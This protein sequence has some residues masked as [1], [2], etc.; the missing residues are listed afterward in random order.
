MIPFIL[1]LLIAG[2]SFIVKDDVT[3]PSSPTVA[4]FFLNRY[5]VM[6]G[7]LTRTSCPEKPVL[8]DMPERKEF[9]KCQ[10]KKTASCF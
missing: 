7:G 10:R 6:K 4:L 1:V 9:F 2:F 5:N 3:S 8:P